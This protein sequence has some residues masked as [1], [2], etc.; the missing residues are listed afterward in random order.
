ML[1]LILCRTDA[2]R[3]TSTCDCWRVL[4]VVLVFGFFSVIVLTLHCTLQ[5]TSLLCAAM[6]AV[7]AVLS[8]LRTVTISV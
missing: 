4:R 6:L 5:Q 8:A 7:W 1:F 3:S 2:N